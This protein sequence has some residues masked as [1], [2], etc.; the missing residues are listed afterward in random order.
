[1]LSKKHGFSLIE[2]MIVIAIL[3]ILASIAVPSYRNYLLRARVSEVINATT[4]AEQAVAVLVQE[5]PALTS[6]TN[7]CSTLAT[8]G[9]SAYSAATTTN[10]SSV[11]IS[12]SCIITATSAPLGGSGGPVVTITANPSLNSDGSL[13]WNCTSNGSMYAPSN[14]Q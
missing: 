11:S 5:N 12:N 9:T 3:A 10:L 7:A 8:G 1:M 13:T 14:C 6:L 4:T 2:I